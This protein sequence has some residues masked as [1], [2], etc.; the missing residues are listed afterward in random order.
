MEYAYNERDFDP[1]PCPIR[2]E[3]AWNVD[4]IAVKDNPRRADRVL[5]E[6]INRERSEAAQLSFR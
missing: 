5:A 1:F 3:C 2:L 4:E 6:L